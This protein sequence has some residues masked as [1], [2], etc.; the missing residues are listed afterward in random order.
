M[1]WIRR[2]SL[3]WLTSGCTSRTL[4]FLCT[5]EEHRHRSNDKQTLLKFSRFHCKEICVSITKTAHSLSHW[6]LVPLSRRT[7]AQW[8][9]SIEHFIK[10][11]F[12][13]TY[14]RKPNPAASW[15]GVNRR[16]LSK[17]ASAPASSNV[18]VDFLLWGN[19][20]QCRGVFPSPS[21]RKKKKVCGSLLSGHWYIYMPKSA[22]LN[23]H[24]HSGI[25]SENLHDILMPHSSSNR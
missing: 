10:L 18:S 24:I 11:S 4:P 8:E 22:H 21:Y 12:T 25:K 6:K 7:I 16:K 3:C 20:E 1:Q 23:I 15:M 14:A 13:L 9:L 5:H 17:L 2:P 19:I